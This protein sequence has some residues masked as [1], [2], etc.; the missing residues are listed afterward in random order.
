MGPVS[1]PRRS[2]SPP[3]RDPSAPSFAGAVYKSVRK[4]DHS[5]L[6]TKTSEGKPTDAGIK[7]F[8][9]TF[10]DS[11]VAELHVKTSELFFQAFYSPCSH[12]DPFG[13][14]FEIVCLSRGRDGRFPSHANEAMEIDWMEVWTQTSVPAQS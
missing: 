13:L 7:L 11:I 12:R 4:L 3:S 5:K 1:R 9:Q 10:K 14:F 8:I 6:K 2:R